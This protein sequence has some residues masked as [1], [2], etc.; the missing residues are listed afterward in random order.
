MGTISGI[1][2][3]SCGSTM[4]TCDDCSPVGDRYYLVCP[5]CLDHEHGVLPPL[6]EAKSPG[7]WDG[8]FGAAPR[9]KRGW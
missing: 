9:R 8:I 4:E 3:A 6:V 5:R 2:C 1:F 7:M